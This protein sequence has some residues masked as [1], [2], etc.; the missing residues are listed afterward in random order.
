VVVFFTLRKF[1]TSAA[2]CTSR[3]R[4]ANSWGGGAGYIYIGVVWR[5][6]GGEEDNKIMKVIFVEL[7]VDGIYQSAPPDR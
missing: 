3:I 2:V 4:P 6:G 7:F 1:Q 5:A